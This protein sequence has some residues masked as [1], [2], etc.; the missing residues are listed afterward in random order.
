MSTPERIG[1]YEVLEAIGRGGFATLYRA[2]DPLM[3]RV[4]AVK[5]CA[6]PDEDQR[7]RFLREAQI[8]GRLDHPNIVRGFDCGFDEA[9]VYRSR[10]TSTVRTCRR[11][12]DRAQRC[13]I[14]TGSRS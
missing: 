2:R 6:E 9:G 4:V 12:S 1:K 8:A 3:Q 5:L 11:R 14:A 10:N 7:R 13:P